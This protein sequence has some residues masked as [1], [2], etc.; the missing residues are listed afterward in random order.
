[1]EMVMAQVDT[2]DLVSVTEIGSK[3]VSHFVTQAAAGRDIV[4]LRNN[5][6][7]AMLIGM[8]HYEQMQRA[9]D[10]AAGT[11]VG[12]LHVARETQHR[13]HDV[14]LG[15]GGPSSIVPARAGLKQ[16]RRLGAGAVEE[17]Q[18]VTGPLEV[19][20]HAA[21][22]D[23]G[24]DERDGGKLRG[25]DSSGK[26]RSAREGKGRLRRGANQFLRAT[27]TRPTLRALHHEHLPPRL[28]DHLTRRRRDHRSGRQG[29]LRRR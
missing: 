21:A 8:E 18:G 11:E 27:G 7:A 5:K 13:D 19:A 20:G 26:K 10:D 2:E 17:V 24:A 25:H 22:H 1:M 3:G 29:G 6:P 9:L 23:A 15:R 28:P 16:R 12:R 14:G 4:V